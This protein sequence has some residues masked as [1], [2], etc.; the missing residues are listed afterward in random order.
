MKYNRDVCQENA[1]IE[2]A[3]KQMQNQ[4]FSSDRQKTK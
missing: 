4:L 2:I 1:R 3:Q